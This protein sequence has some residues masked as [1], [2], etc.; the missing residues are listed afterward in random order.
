MDGSKEH[1]II[2]Y[3]KVVGS[4]TTNKGNYIYLN[5]EIDDQEDRNIKI[6]LEKRKN[7]IGDKEYEDDYYET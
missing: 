5:D 7:N 1:L 2:D 4:N 3:D 6:Y